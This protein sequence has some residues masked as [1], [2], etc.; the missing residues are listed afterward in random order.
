MNA[1]LGGDGIIYCN[2]R[3]FTNQ[4]ASVHIPIVAVMGG[5]YWGSRIDS[6]VLLS[7]RLVSSGHVVAR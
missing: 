6:L 1:I 2:L 5:E 4:S 3:Q 7:C